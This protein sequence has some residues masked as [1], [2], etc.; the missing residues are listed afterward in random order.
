[1]DNFQIMS[2]TNFSHHGIVWTESLSR[3]YREGWTG[4]KI[5]LSSRAGA[6]TGRLGIS[7]EQ[8]SCN[9]HAKQQDKNEF[10]GDVKRPRV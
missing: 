1:M 8:S 4:P 6:S 10:M 3:D 2:P 7:S 5:Q 9:I